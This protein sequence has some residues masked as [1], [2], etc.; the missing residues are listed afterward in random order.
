MLRLLGG[1][2]G[3]DSEY[4][5]IRHREVSRRHDATGPVGQDGTDDGWEVEGLEHTGDV[6]LEQSNEGG[7]LCEMRLT[8]SCRPGILFGTVARDCAILQLSHP[9]ILRRVR[10]SI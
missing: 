6:W 7:Q 1:N 5:R 2:A 3:G 4:H 8:L 9:E 10:N